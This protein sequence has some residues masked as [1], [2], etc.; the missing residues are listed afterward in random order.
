VATQLWLEHEGAD[1]LTDL[2]D[3]A[4]ALLDAGLATL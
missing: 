2:V 1:S 3:E 4:F